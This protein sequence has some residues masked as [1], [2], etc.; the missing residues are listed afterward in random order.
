MQR[1]TGAAAM[2]RRLAHDARMIRRLRSC[3]IVLGLGMAACSVAGTSDPARARAQVD[4]LPCQPNHILCIGDRL[5]YCTLSGN[6]AVLGQDCAALGSAN[7]P[8]ACVTSGCP[9]GQTACC[10]AAKARS[11][12][13]L[14]APV[15]LA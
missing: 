15:P 4:A 1:V 8:A 7:N 9:K 2:G 12:W 5:G 11:K 6:D 10:L 14:S 3:F 13:S